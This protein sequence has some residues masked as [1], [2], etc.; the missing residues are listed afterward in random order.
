MRKPIAWEDLWIQLAVLISQRSKDPNTQV[1][2]VL[3]SPDQRRIAI[4]YNGFAAGIPENDERWQRPTKYDYVI[5]AEENALINSRANVDGW[6]AYLTMPPCHH[7]AS[8]LIQAGI[9][10]VL[11]LNEPSSSAFNYDLSYQLLKEA[12]ME[13]GKYQR[14]GDNNE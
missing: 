7:C 1:G 10:K 2:V 12:G 4:G 8:K 5:H 9:K 11:W 13:F 3:V 14:Q 6:T